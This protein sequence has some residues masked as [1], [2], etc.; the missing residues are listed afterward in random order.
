MAEKQED[1]KGGSHKQKKKVDYTKKIRENPWIISTV[2]LAVLVL[3]VLSGSVGNC[4]TGKT[5]SEQ[6]SKDEAGSK[7]EQ[8]AQSQGLNASVTGV[9]EEKGFFRVLMKVRGQKTS[10]YVTKDGENLIPTG[11]VQPLETTNN[12]DQQNTDDQNNQ[13]SQQ[14]S[15][16][17]SEKPEV[18]LFVMSYCPYGTQAQKGI[19]P[20]AEALGDNVDFDIKF[21]N[22]L[23]HGEKEG[24]ENTRQYCIQKEQEDKFMDYM[25]CFLD[26]GNSE[27]CLEEANIDKQQLQSCMDEADEKFNITALIDDKS[28]Y[29]G[30]RFPQYNVH[31]DLNQEYGVQG[32]PTLVINGKKVQ[33]SRSPAAYLDTI[34]S[35]FTEDS[36]PSVCEEADLET[37][38]YSTMFGYDVSSGSTGGSC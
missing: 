3:L 36:K 35:A 12:Q 13:D 6:I 18:E 33:S 26:S 25:T 4:F 15:A 21:V 14:T 20:A 32:S 38:S 30:G 2:V 27:P 23:M 16:P 17:K 9:E 29:R 7:I 37:Q 1:K 34:C 8:F 24:M 11:A 5:I 28:S 22:Y 31:N 10:I 19:L